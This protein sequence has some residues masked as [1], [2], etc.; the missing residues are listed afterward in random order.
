MTGAAIATLRYSMEVPNVL[1][2]SLSVMLCIISTVTVFSLLLITIFHAF[3]RRDLFPNDIAI[4]ISDKRPKTVRKWY[5]RRS[6]S[7]DNKDHY[8]KFTDSNDKD[9][10]ACVK[11]SIPENNEENK[12]VTPFWNN[13]FIAMQ[14]MKKKVL[15]IYAS[16]TRAKRGVRPS[17]LLRQERN[18]VLQLSKFQWRCTRRIECED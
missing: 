13:Y 5:H 4:A 3:V 18:L 14:C 15:I 1:T 8:L 2:K 10:E 6:G 12:T 16:K 7:S 17:L 9:I 11:S